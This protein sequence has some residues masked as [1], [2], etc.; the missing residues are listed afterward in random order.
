MGCIGNAPAIG[1]VLFPDCTTPAHSRYNPKALTLAISAAFPRPPGGAHGSEGQAGCR[2]GPLAMLWFHFDA[3]KT[4]TRWKE[5]NDHNSILLVS[6]TEESQFA[7]G[8][9]A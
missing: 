9:T 8:E 1:F 4:F 3:F 2:R 5:P 6:S 7:D